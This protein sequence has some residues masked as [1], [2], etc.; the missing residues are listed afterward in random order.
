MT[1]QFDF[2]NTTLEGLKIVQR[3]AIE[4]LRGYLCR[5]YCAKDFAEQGFNKSVSQINQTL[6]YQKGS[7]RGLHYQFMPHTEIKLVSCVKGEIFDVAVDIRKGSSTF[8]KWH[9]EVL[10]E[11]NQK[12]ILIPEGFAHGF[13]SLTDNCELLYL[14]SSH[15]EKD[16]EAALNINDPRLAITFPLSITD[17]SERDR[18]HP[19][20]DKNF[21]GVIL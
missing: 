8:L 18:S 9:S 4:D 7:V 17:I 3:K 10:S 6:T 5:V 19:Y 12:S 14:H 16:S 15:Y 1:Q 13:Q 2:T 21:E 20:I 11:K